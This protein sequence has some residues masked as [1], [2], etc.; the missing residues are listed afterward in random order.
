M[1][2]PQDLF[3]GFFKKVLRPLIGCLV[4][5]FIIYYVGLD[6]IFNKIKL[7]DFR[8]I[9]LTGVFVF[10]SFLFGFG[11]AFLLAYKQVDMSWKV[12]LMGYWIAW[13]FSL[14]V[15]GQ[16]GGILSLSLWMK[17]LGLRWEVGTAVMAVDK[18]VSLL[19]MMFFAAFGIG[20]YLG[21]LQITFF[22]VVLLVAIVLVGSV[23]LFLFRDRLLKEDDEKRGVFFRIIKAII[24]TTTEQKK[25][26]LINILVTPVTITIGAGA[27]WAVFLAVGVSTDF[28]QVLPLVAVSALVAYIPVSLNGVGT[29]ELAG[30]TLFATIGMDA[31]SILT[32]YI[33]LRLTV[34]TIAWVPSLMLMS[35]PS[36]GA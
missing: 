3:K 28:I 26:L 13:A 27:Y 29:A 6:D 18:V 21:H 12:F 36:R 15:P 2:I 5:S 16:V 9:L 34:M 1:T 30:L 25:E 4:I 19:W 10:V 7:V 35:L 11:N 23:G 22:L 14:I 31:T 17:K 20:L 24:L 32:A 33:L 8:Y